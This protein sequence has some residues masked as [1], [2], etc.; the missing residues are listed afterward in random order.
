MEDCI[1][2]KINNHEIPTDIIYSNEDFFVI[3]DIKP[4][5]EIHDLIISKKHI[6]SLQKL[7][8]DEKGLLGD[9]LLYAQSLAIKYGL[10][11]QGYKIEI[12][13]GPA[14][15]QE[16]MHLHIHFLGG[17]SINKQ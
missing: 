15:G 3:K 13:T 17:K 4:K 11:E 5:A 2:C 8:Q 10:S 7:S 6:I 1:F 12:N 16:V 9:M 14:G